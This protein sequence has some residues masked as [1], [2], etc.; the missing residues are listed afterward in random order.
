M[1]SC[2]KKRGYLGI[3]LDASVF[4]S[5]DS[6]YE[7]RNNP[8]TDAPMEFKYYIGLSTIVLILTVSVV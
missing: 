8:W 3:L 1:T 5:T 4:A 7:S 6:A 2:T